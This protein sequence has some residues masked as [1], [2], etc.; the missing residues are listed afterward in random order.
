MIAE[1]TGPSARRRICPYATARSGFGTLLGKALADL[2]RDLT[3][4][5]FIGRLDRC[6]ELAHFFSFQPS[7]QLALGFAGA[8]YQNGFRG[9]DARDNR[10]VLEVE[11]TGQDPLADII[12]GC[13]PGI[14]GAVTMGTG[15]MLRLFRPGNDQAGLMPFVRYRH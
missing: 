5:H 11:M 13:L 14:I 7:F 3:I 15:M 4:G 10:I 12:R 1:H 6:D 9:P 8:E 2:G